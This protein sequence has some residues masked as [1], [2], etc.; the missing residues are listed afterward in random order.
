MFRPIQ[1]FIIFAAFTLH[2]QDSYYHS[3]K[4]HFRIKFPSGWT[5]EKGDR[6]DMVV[7]ATYLGNTISIIAGPFISGTVLSEAA[8]NDSQLKALP[9]DSLRQEITRTFSREDVIGI[10]KRCANN[11]EYNLLNYEVSEIGTSTIGGRNCGYFI[12]KGDRIMFI[13]QI[14]SK[15]VNMCLVDNGYMYIISAGSPLEDFDSVYTQTLKPCI[16]SFM[17]QGGK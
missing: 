6:K 7:K 14:K 4:Y 8:A 17:L 16:E 15:M 3:E 11:N 10:V 2:A 1:L 13:D 12:C 5:I 9:A